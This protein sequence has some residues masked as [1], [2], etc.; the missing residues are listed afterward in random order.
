MGTLTSSTTVT[1]QVSPPPVLD[2]NG[3]IVSYRVSY[4][5]EGAGIDDVMT[6]E[7]LST[8]ED[9]QRLT[10]TG[11][12]PGSAYMYSVRAATAVGA[13]TESFN[14][15]FTTADEGK[16]LRAAAATHTV[17]NVCLLAS[18]SCSPMAMNSACLLPFL[19]LAQ[20]VV[21]VNI[22]FLQ[23]EYRV[24]E[25]E[26]NVSVSITVGIDPLATTPINLTIA[27]ID[28]NT[29]YRALGTVARSPLIT[30]N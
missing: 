23:Q 29:T 14:M 17:S 5:K 25:S 19:L 27:T 28:V 21:N 11:L 20:S 22:T 18:P 1:I 3:I 15:S 6:M 4:R 13:G 7:F 30:G 8:G 2:R 24:T 16:S 9:P 26:R 12:D 10:L